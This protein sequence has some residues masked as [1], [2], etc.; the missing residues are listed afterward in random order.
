MTLL[1]VYLLACL[2]TGIIM[3]INT[4]WELKKPGE[5]IT[6]GDFLTGAFF[7][8]CPFLNFIAAVCCVWYFL[9]EIAP[10]ITLVRNDR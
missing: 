6:L 3:C 5:K 8:F 4:W 1:Q 9:S 10:S 7:T 2:A